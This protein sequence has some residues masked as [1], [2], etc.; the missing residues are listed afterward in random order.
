MPRPRSVPARRGLQQH[1]KYDDA[2]EQGA[3]DILNIRCPL[4]L[5]AMRTAGRLIAR[6]EAQLGRALTLEEGYV[7][8]ESGPF[9]SRDTLEWCHRRLVVKLLLL[10]P[11][12]LTPIPTS[13]VE[14][15]ARGRNRFL[16]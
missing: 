10:G 1:S 3:H 12:S 4:T 5:A 16:L 14:D 11:H 15:R 7:C 13:D 6:R 2:V 8:V 9:R